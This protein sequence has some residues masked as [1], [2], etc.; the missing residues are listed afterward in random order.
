VAAA[1]YGAGT[2]PIR[3]YLYGPSGGSYQTIGAAENTTGVWDGF[4]PMVIGTPMSAPY[5]F[6]IRAM[7]QVVL[8][9]KAEQIA[10]AV[11]PGGD[12]RPYARL[13]EAERDMLRELTSFGVPLAGWQN[14]DYLL[15]T[16]K[17]TN[18]FTCGRAFDPAYV[19]A[20]WSKPG[21]LGTSDSPLG[22]V[23]QAALVDAYA[24]IASVEGT[25][26]T[27]VTLAGVPAVTRT[28]QLDYT[29]Y[30]ADGQKIGSLAG[31]LD[32]ATGT[33]TIGSGNS[34]TVL[35]ALVK[36]AQVRIDNRSSLAQCSF[37][38][39]N[40]PAASDRHAGWD[41][42]RNSAGAPLYPQHSPLL[43]PL[44]TQSISGGATYS[45]KITGKVMVVDNLVDVDAPAT[46]ANWYA[47]RVEAALG[48]A[49]SRAQFR[50]Y[51]NDNADHLDAPP[52]DGVRATYLVDWY[53][54]VYQALRDVSAWAE[55]GVSAP[56]STQ[57]RADGAI[58]SV[59]DR[60]ATRKGLQPV[61][62][63]SANGR[64]RVD[65]K[66]GKPVL[67]VADAETPTGTGKIVSAA[68][69][70]S[71]TGTYAPAWIGTPRDRKL[72]VAVHRFTAPGTYFVAV[73][74]AS[75][76]TGS[77]TDVAQVEN[78]DRVRVVVH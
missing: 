78:L 23:F 35:G 12:G 16:P 14:P 34:T 20:F 39:H 63:L 50:V 44:F 26:P 76:R 31:A 9:D 67:F 46:A 43:G 68:W 54:S 32:P 28:S 36:G 29:V 30:S 74:V 53:G 4:V 5:V 62:H 6:D 8:A 42:F 41:Q 49:G 37:H 33:F 38:R 75:S 59:P 22:K 55:R 21:Y 52:V 70:F 64:D 58:I 1:Y 19:D 69:D 61:V 65:V 72:V 10:D 66:A 13:D 77:R 45:G 51:L 60:A 24:T 56:A 11:R 57:Y 73:K 7:A 48:K 25:P 40:L 3:G 15:G 18:P 27:T 47:G 2:R 17:S 71:G